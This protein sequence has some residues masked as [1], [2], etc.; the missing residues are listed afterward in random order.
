MLNHEYETTFIF[1]PDL[2]EAEHDRVKD[3]LEAIITEAGGEVL[4]FEDWGR[5]RL[6]Y[7]IKKHQYGHYLLWN[8]VAPPSVPGEIERIV[9][10]EEPIIRFLTI[11]NTELVDVEEVRAIA[12]ERQRK[13]AAA[14]AAQAAESE[15]GHRGDRDDRDRRD[16]RGSRDDRG[17]REERAAPAPAAPAAPSDDA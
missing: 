17:P 3:R 4:I 5:R 15:S 11:K 9:R 8:Y 1:R 13:R 10:I 12:E 6:A 16:D 14:L 7:T 2:D